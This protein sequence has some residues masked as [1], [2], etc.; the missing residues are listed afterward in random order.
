[1]TRSTVLLGAAAIAAAAAPAGAQIGVAFRDGTFADADW[2]ATVISDTS[3]GH[4]G[5]FLA[6]QVGA[7]GNPGAYRYV[8]HNYCQGAFIVGHL[9]AGAVYDPA[10]QGA[11]TTISGSYDLTHINPPPG[12]GV[13]YGLLLRQG[14]TYYAVAAGDTVTGTGWAAFVAAPTPASGFQRVT[15]L[16][17]EQPNFSATGAPMQLGYYSGN[18]STSG[19]LQR[20]SGI[21]NWAVVVGRACPADTD[22]NG[23]VNIQDL[24]TFIVGFSEGD[25]RGDFNV[26][27]AVNIQDLFAFIQAFAEGCA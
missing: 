9:R 19:C 3:A 23:T 13:G 6:Q 7:G 21:D 1:M 11:A 20:E 22:H 25:S 12:Q 5:T 4:V 15:G 27:G 2:A 18:T 26:D 24:F 14:D 8:R 17:P 10:V 16:G